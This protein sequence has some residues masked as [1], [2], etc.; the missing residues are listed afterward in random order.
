VATITVGYFPSSLLYDPANGYVYV[1]V[2]GSGR[3]VEIS[4]T[5]IV[6]TTG[7]LNLPKA[8]CFNPSNSAV[9]VANF[10]SGVVSEI[11]G[12]TLTANITVG[13]DPAALAFDLT[14]IT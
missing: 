5:S 3:V 8:L 6:G 7:K 4:G 10:G 11:V 9:Y 2:G 12:T 1:A 14:T 13:V